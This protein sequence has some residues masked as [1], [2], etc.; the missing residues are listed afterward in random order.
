L[1]LAG[2]LRASESEVRSQLISGLW[3]LISGRTDPYIIRDRDSLFVADND[4]L[5]TFVWS[6]WEALGAAS[7]Q[8]SIHS[9]QLERT[10]TTQDTVFIFGGEP[11]KTYSVEILPMSVTGENLGTLQSRAILCASAILDAPGKPE[12]VSAE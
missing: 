5:L 7:Y 12:I 1:S 10:E 3:P 6:S 9:P 4:T 2:D 8:V 11:Q